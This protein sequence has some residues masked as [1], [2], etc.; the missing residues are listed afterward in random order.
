MMVFLSKIPTIFTFNFTAND[1]K[2]FLDKIN[3]GICG[4][5]MHFYR[6]FL[7]P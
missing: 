3:N 4:N 5:I 2:R 7:Q 1:G 6:Q